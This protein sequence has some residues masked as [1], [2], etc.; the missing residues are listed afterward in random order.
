MTKL[1]ADLQQDIQRFSSLFAGLFAILN[2]I[3]LFVLLYRWFL[4][5]DSN[6]TEK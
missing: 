3:G 2:K 6:E 5:S 1:F 4:P